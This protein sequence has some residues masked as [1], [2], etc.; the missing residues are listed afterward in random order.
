VRLALG[1]IALLAAAPALALEA[2]PG[3]LGLIPGYDEPYPSFTWQGAWHSREVWIPSE[4][5]G[6]RLFA[7][8]FAPAPQPLSKLPAVV[9]LPGSIVGVQAG[10]QWAA[11]DLAGHGYVAVTIDPQGQGRS[12]LFSLPPCQRPGD[13]G[14]ADVEQ[15]PWFI[16]IPNWLDALSSALDW[17][18][19]AADPFGDLVDTSRLGA[20]GHSLGA[21]VVSLAQGTEPRLKA[22]VAWDNLASLDQG[23]AGSAKCFGSGNAVV[24]RVPAMG[25]ASEACGILPPEAKKT[26][27]ERW[28][29]AG[30]PTMELVFRGAEH[31]DWHQARDAN[32][33]GG[34]ESQLRLFEHYQ[35]AWF[36][37]FLRGD[38]S[39]DARLLAPSVDGVPRAALLSEQFLSA[40]FLPDLGIDCADFRACP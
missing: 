32:G 4:A 27:Y 3:P 28:R 30:L 15:Q 13:F 12:E 38:T 1:L 17:L 11:R 8:V 29:A 10:D 39:A 9:M 40:A 18:P 19:T 26:A 25:Q 24:P 31:I 34:N 16:S 37:R 33:F 35:R 14:C 20:T 7:T 23:D 21:H 6:A 2:V 22:I 5:T 36:D